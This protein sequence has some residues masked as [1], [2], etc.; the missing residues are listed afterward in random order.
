[1]FYSAGQRCTQKFSNLMVK[2]VVQDG[3]HGGERAAEAEVVVQRRGVR[4][5]RVGRRVGRR[6]GQQRRQVVRVD[7]RQER[8]GPLLR[9]HR[10]RVRA[11]RYGRGGVALEGGVG[12]GQAGEGGADVEWAV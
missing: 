9:Q 12:G 4:R 10:C 5:G 1:M 6:F 2:R 8:G 7:A 11:L 3:G